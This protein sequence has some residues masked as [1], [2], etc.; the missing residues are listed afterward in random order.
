LPEFQEIA[1]YFGIAAAYVK[2]QPSGWLIVG[3]VKPR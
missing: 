1:G 3:F 2:P